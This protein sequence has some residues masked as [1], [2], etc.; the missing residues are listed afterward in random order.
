MLFFAPIISYA[1]LI[2]ASWLVGRRRYHDALSVLDKIEKHIP[3]EPELF[4]LRGRVQRHLQLY[5]PSISDYSKLV[6]LEPKRAIAF[7]ER[8]VSLRLHGR[9]REAFVDID[10]AIIMGCKSARAYCERAHALYSLGEYAQ[11]M[12]DYSMALK[13]SPEVEYA[14]DGL[15]SCRN[16]LDA[17]NRG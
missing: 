7:L 4:S 13:L 8:G 11:A 12:M 9:V 6:M 2:Y 15:N 16:C 17:A 14:Q 5:E 3:N 1:S 10:K